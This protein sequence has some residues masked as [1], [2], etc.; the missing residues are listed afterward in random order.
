MV[1]MVAFG[2]YCL[3]GL[4]FFIMGIVYMGDAGTIG[5][6]GIYMMALGIIMLII[7]GIALW[8]NNGSKWMLLFVIELIN[9]ALFLFLY[10]FIVVVL[11]MA[12]GTTDPV[13]D[14]TEET[15]DIT[16]PTL[17]IPGSD[18]D[19]DPVFTYCQTQGGANCVLYYDA[20]IKS[21]TCQWLPGTV[22]RR[23]WITA[24]FCS[25]TRRKV[26]AARRRTQTAQH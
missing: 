18:P 17:T 10:C 16:K 8:A 1:L 24:R 5:A 14:A 22:R 21:A 19:G 7:G 2:V 3:M 4:I 20:A 25:T 13:S 6:T 23:Y 12:S 15:W 11:L 9:I 26:W